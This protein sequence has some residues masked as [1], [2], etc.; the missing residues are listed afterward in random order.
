MYSQYHEVNFVFV[1]LFVFGWGNF[2][3]QCMYNSM[4]DPW[5]SIKPQ[6]IKLGLVIMLLSWIPGSHIITRLSSRFMAYYSCA[7]TIWFREW[8]EHLFVKVLLYQKLSQNES[9]TCIKILK[10]G[11][12]IKPCSYFTF[13]LGTLQYMAP[14]VI[15]KGIRGHGAPVSRNCIWNSSPCLSCCLWMFFHLLSPSNPDNVM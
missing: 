12:E 3:N 11:S 2:D 10:T 4:A 13:V 6:P 8:I 7:S 1:C 5:C 15:D 9:I 14:E